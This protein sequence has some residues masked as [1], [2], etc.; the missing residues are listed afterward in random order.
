M[1]FEKFVR[2]RVANRSD[3]IASLSK[4]H[5]IFNAVAARLAQLPSKSNVIYHI[6]EESR[7]V[8]FEFTSDAVD[9]SS[10]A[11]FSKKGSNVFRSSIG[12]V[13]NRYPWVR[14]VALLRDSEDRRF[15]MKP[16]AKLWVIQLCP[17]FE[18]SVESISDVPADAK[19]IYQYLDTR[20]EIIYIG[21]GNIRQRRADQGRDDW[22]ISRIQYSIVNGDDKQ[23][24]WERYWIEKY[25]EKHDGNLPPFNRV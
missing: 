10:Y 17:A 11:I 25:K 21:K 9:R 16:E 20:G 23:Y 18:H 3:P 24:E 19:G 15:Q 7:K 8:G 12:E 6:E 4:S 2:T 14:S 13:C 22:R 1:A 5:V